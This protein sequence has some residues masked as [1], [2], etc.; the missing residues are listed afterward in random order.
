[1]SSLYLSSIRPV[2]S[3]ILSRSLDKRIDV[4]A[5]YIVVWLNPVSMALS[6]IS[7]SNVKAL[8]RSGF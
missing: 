5:G 1:M 2:Y 7:R 6:S 3:I 4:S 8:K